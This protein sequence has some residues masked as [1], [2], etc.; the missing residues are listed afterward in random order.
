MNLFAIL[1]PAS[2]ADMFCA[3]DI[4]PAQLQRAVF[5]LDLGR[6]PPEPGE[7]EFEDADLATVKATRLEIERMRRRHLTD[8]TPTPVWPIDPSKPGHGDL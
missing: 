8:A 1:F 2:F 6:D 4:R 5:D 7:P 3:D